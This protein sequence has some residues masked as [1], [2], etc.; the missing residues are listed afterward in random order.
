MAKNKYHCR[1]T[2]IQM[3][4]DYPSTLNRCLWHKT[5]HKALASFSRAIFQTQFASAPIQDL[6][7]RTMSI[8]AG[9]LPYPAVPELSGLLAFCKKNAV[10]IPS[11]DIEGSNKDDAS[12]AF[13][14]WGLG[15]GRSPTSRIPTTNI[16]DSSVSVSKAR[17]ANGNTGATYLS[18]IPK[19]DEREAPRPTIYEQVWSLLPIRTA[20]EH[21]LPPQAFH[22]SHEAMSNTSS[23]PLTGQGS[24]RKS[25]SSELAREI[26]EAGGRFPPPRPPKP[27]KYSASTGMPHGAIPSAPPL[28]DVNP[29]A[30]ATF[31]EL[32]ERYRAAHDGPAFSTLALAHLMNSGATGIDISSTFPLAAEIIGM[33]QVLTNSASFHAYFEDELTPDEADIRVSAFRV[34]TRLFDHYVRASVIFSGNT[35]ELKSLLRN[36]D[37]NER[38]AELRR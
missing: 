6:L 29:Q 26:K 1:R 27:P 33:F 5:N 15:F 30:V 18:V 4:S 16:E 36:T 11:I 28:S 24:Q 13:L 10:T 31:A 38:K 35:A 9:M 34:V 25:L 2:G 17:Q 23:S 22:S 20:G 32:D 12:E 21:L 37:Y 7:H 19:Q 3:R 8:P 14:Q